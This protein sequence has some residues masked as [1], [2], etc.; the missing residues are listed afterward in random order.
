MMR[1]TY[2]KEEHVK[3]DVKEVLKEL[4]ILYHMPRPFGM[5]GVADFVCCYE[6][7][8]VEIETKFGYNKQTDM[9]KAW[10]AKVTRHKGIYMVIDETNVGQ[11]SEYLLE[12]HVSS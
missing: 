7:M 6:G 3:Q 11:L 1:R 10:E 12:L 4:G 5:V 8:Y 9:Q 2:E